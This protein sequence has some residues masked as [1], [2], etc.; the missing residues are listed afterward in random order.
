MLQCMTAAKAGDDNRARLHG[1][2]ASNL[3]LYEGEYRFLY[4]S[5]LEQLALRTP[6]DAGRK[7]LELAAAQMRLAV[8][9]TLAPVN[10]LVSLGILELRLGRFDAAR[11]AIERAEQMSPTSGLV[12]LAWS[13]YHLQRGELE[14]AILRYRRAEELGTLWSRLAPLHDDIREAINGSNEKRRLRRI[15]LDVAGMKARKGKGQ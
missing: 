2:R 6:G 9:D 5:A 11:A 3:G 13:T 14:E 15:F 4:A 12:F 1:D 10:C 8:E 7:R